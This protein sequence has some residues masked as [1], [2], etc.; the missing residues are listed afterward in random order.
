M[1]KDKHIVRSSLSYKAP[2]PLGQG[3]VTIRRFDEPFRSGIR[4]SERQGAYGI[5]VRKERV[6][7]TYQAEPIPEIQLPG[8]GIDRNESPLQA[9]RREV[10]E[11]TGWS[12][13]V[14][15]LLGT[16]RRYTYMPEYDL[17]ARKTHRVY[18]CTAVRRMGLPTELGHAALWSTPLDGLKI[19][20]A[21][22]DK[23]MLAKAITENCIP[24]TAIDSLPVC[25][26]GF[27]QPAKQP[28]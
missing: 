26:I 18:F 10:L 8:G 27:R 7:L 13:R 23:A 17:W 14:N 5:I 1:R 6:L 3:A 21:Q 9:L 15:R 25:Q 20:S 12:L 22:G 19:L 16:Y 28:F 4:Y 24:M 11:E 2:R